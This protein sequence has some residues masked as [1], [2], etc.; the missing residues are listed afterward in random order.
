MRYNY[1]EPSEKSCATAPACPAPPPAL[2]LVDQL[3]RRR[4]DLVGPR[5]DIEMKLNTIR[6]LLSALEDGPCR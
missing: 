6:H 4:I 3:K 2:S 1:D 5:D